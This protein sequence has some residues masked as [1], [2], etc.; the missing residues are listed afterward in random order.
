MPDP[1]APRPGGPSGG[2]S[3]SDRHRSSGRQSSPSFA[4]STWVVAHRELGAYFDSAIA[5]VYASAFLVLSC[6]AFM[7]A[8]FLASVAD[9][10]AYFASLPFLLILF[11]PA[12]TMRTWSEERAQQ[13]FELVVTLP[14]RPLELI[15]GKYLAA[16]LFYLVILTGSLPI[17]VM[18][19]VLGDPDLGLIFAGYL[20]A[21]CLGA[22]LLA[23]GVF[24]SSLTRNQ[25]V[26]FVL[27]AVLACLLVFS[28]HAAVV[29]VV[30]GLSPT[31]QMGTWM[32]E[33]LS[34]LPHYEAFTGGLIG[35]GHL[36]YFGL[37]SGFF[38]WMNELALRRSRM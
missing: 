21:L 14:L 12:I 29:E 23:G 5:Y 37:L 9:M 15:L 6:S 32:Y 18:L 11:A 27:A 26:A 33:S 28:G 4:S 31:W 8:F 19:L 10:S 30:D 1:G 24:V 22:L 7:N 20:G 2:Q 25:V 35:L 3:S 34:V 13:T 36:L 17:V 38:L 16:L